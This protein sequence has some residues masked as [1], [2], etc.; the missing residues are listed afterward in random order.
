MCFP[1]SLDIVVRGS[2]SLHILLPVRNFKSTFPSHFRGPNETEIGVRGRQSS[3]CGHP[4]HWQA[5]HALRSPSFMCYHAS[6]KP[7]NS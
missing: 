6:H 5:L 2:S 1:F 7:H 4:V 3:K